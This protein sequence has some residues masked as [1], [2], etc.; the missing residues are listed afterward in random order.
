MKQW[1]ER[2]GR[3]LAE[4]AAGSAPE[5]RFSVGGGGLRGIL[6]KADGSGALQGL[7]QFGDL[8]TKRPAQRTVQLN[9][10]ERSVFL[11]LDG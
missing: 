3:T 8:G 2:E 6:P 1:V 9:R 11:G 4:V 7:L 5:D 10:K